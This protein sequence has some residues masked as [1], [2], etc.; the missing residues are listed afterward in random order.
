MRMSKARKACVSAMMK[1][2][3]FEA[4]T[5]VLEQHGVGGMTMEGV[6]TTAELGTA[7]LYTYFREQDELLQF[8]YAVGRSVFPGDWRR[9]SAPTF[10]RRKSWKGFSVLRWSGPINTRASFDSWRSPIENLT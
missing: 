6:A 7:S 1:D 2:T 10:P 5:S 8:I 4:A 3:I 9:S